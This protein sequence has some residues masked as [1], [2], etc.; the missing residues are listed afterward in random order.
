MFVTQCRFHSHLWIACKLAANKAVLFLFLLVPKVC[1]H[2]MNAVGKEMLCLWLCCIAAVT[3]VGVCAHHLPT[4]AS[5]A[6]LW[7]LQMLLFGWE[8][9]VVC[10][11]PCCL[12]APRTCEKQKLGETFVKADN[13]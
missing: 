8:G 13:T 6:C 4:R 2:G 12:A 10:V 1:C 7:Y 5:D 9:T 11:C 3:T